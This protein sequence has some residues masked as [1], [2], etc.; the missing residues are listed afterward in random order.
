MNEIKLIGEYLVLDESPQAMTQ[1]QFRERHGRK[2]AIAVALTQS[3]NVAFQ[4]IGLAMLIERRVGHSTRSRIT[5]LLE[6]SS[7]VSS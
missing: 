5:Q 6:R 3:E 2:K 1:D 4:E 7:Q